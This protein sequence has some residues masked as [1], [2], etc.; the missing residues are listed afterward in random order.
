QRQPNT[1]PPRQLQS[2]NSYNPLT[3]QL[4]FSNQGVATADS[5]AGTSD[6][7]A[8]SVNTSPIAKSH[9]APNTSTAPST[10]TTDPGFPSLWNQIS[11]TS[12]RSAGSANDGG[13]IRQAA[14]WSEDNSSQPQSQAQP[15]PAQPAAGFWSS[16]AR[17]L[18]AQTSDTPVRRPA[19]SQSAE[20]TAD[21]E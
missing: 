2:P 4:G 1:A 19:P 21:S 18:T 10:A 17:P 20:T 3:S 6:Q 15:E 11:G 12:T 14:A 16:L 13:D 7:P 8:A 5:S 9:P